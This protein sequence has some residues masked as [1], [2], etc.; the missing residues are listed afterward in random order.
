MAPVFAIILL[1][2]K[3]LLG[4]FLFLP[5]AQWSECTHNGVSAPGNHSQMIFLFL[6]SQMHANS[7]TS[8]SLG[9]CT[10]SDERPC[11]GSQWEGLS[12]H[13]L[14][15]RSWK[16][17]RPAWPPGHRGKRDWG[18][19]KA[20]ALL[21]SHTQGLCERPHRITNNRQ[22][23]DYSE[24]SSLAFWHEIYFLPCKATG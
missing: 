14:P 5:S 12:L 13:P 7:M 2:V 11:S 9:H 20:W 1:S 6:C 19:I 24:Q 18:G 21:N 15:L 3:L 22:R 16:T 10:R 17:G 4:D 8:P 23:E